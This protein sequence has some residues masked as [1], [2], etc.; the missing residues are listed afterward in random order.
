MQGR[1]VAAVGDG[2]ALFEPGLILGVD[3]NPTATRA[4]DALQCLVVGD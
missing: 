3:G 1:V 2:A 4:Q